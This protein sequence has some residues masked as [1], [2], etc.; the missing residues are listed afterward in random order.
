VSGAAR[1]GP[2]S[3]RISVTDRCQLGCFYCMPPGG[4]V[5]RG[6]SEILTFEEIARF[7]RVLGEELGLSKVRLTGGEPLVRRGLAEL[8]AMLAGESA[9]DLALTTN[10]RLLAAMAADL[11]RAGLRRVNVSLDS[12]DPRTYA[13]ICGGGDPGLVVE[14]IEAARRAGLAPVKLNAVVLR[15]LNDREVVRLA[16]FALGRGCAIRFLELMPIGCARRFFAE[17]FVPAAQVRARLAEAF[18]LRAL[19]RKPGQSSREF[20]A[21]D[22]AGRR[23]TVGFIASETQPFCAGCRRLRLTSTGQVIG[24]LARGEGPSVREFLR[25]D[26]DSCRRGLIGVVAEAL[27]SKRLRAGYRTPQPMVAVGG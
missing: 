9:P 16:R 5:R 17:R 1:A 21:D 22:G 12:L 10:G 15:S 2:V 3:L 27:S 20:L 7:V 6:R 24:C 13:A 26:S 19:P 18:E 8:I 4:V 23:G 11:R 25:D 14:G